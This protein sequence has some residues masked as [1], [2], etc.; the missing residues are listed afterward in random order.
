VHAAIVLHFGTV[1]NLKDKDAIGVLV[2]TTLTR[3]TAKKNRQQIQR[4]D[5]PA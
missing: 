4:R 3:G 5:G 1:E 2:G